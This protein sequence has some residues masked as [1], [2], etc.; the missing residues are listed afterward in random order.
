LFL[1]KTLFVLEEFSKKEARFE[2]ENRL[3]ERKTSG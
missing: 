1:L 3:L 2:E